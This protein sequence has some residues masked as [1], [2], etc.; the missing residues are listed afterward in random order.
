ML[1]VKETAQNANYNLVIRK[2]N[3]CKNLNIS[4]VFEQLADNTISKS[5]ST[6]SWQ[7]CVRS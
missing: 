6:L 4:V 1:S 5:E 7:K 3:N 2:L